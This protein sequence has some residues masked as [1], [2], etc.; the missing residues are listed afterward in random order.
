MRLAVLVSLNKTLTI[1]NSCANIFPVTLQ[2]KRLLMFLPNFFTLKIHPTKTLD[3]AL[4]MRNMPC[5]LYSLCVN[6]TIITNECLQKLLSHWVTRPD[7]HYPTPL[8]RRT[9]VSWST[10]HIANRTVKKSLLFTL[11]SWLG[12]CKQATDRMYSQ[13]EVHAI[14]SF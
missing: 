2:G 13:E 12:N 14:E 7:I 11:C 10:C 1:S 6:H 8:A 3:L 5:P 4:V 9:H